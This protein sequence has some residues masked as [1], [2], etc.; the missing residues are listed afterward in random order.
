MRKSITMTFAA[1]ALLAATLGAAPTASAQSS[2]DRFENKTRAHLAQLG[3]EEGDVKSIRIV[4]RRRK[5][6]RG[7]DIIGAE[8][9][10]RLNSCSGW[11]VVEMTRAA[12]VRQSYTRGDCSI[13]GVPNY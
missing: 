13:A 10:V 6:D 3:V 9:W 12:F 7:P 8:G 1:A 11:L 2:N 5:N 4:V